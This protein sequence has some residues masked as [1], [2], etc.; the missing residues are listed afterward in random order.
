M[1]LPPRA[2]AFHLLRVASLRLKTLPVIF[3]HEARGMKCQQTAGLSDR[4]A[5]V[6]AL[7]PQKPLPVTGT[8]YWRA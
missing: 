4:M 1:F 7:C 3:G 2:G 5:R 8:R 6:S